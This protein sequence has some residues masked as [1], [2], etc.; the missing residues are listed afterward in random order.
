MTSDEFAR[1]RPVDRGGPATGVAADR[2]PAPPRR[3]NSPQ[4]PR[5]RRRRR[6]QV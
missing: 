3:R 6:P 4:F 5:P 1:S 2:G